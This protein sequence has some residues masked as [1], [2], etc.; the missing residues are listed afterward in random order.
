MPARARTLQA[1]L[2]LLA[3]V[4]SNGALAQYSQPY[5]YPPPPPP[6]GY[7]PAP[8]QPAP[9][10]YGPPREPAEPARGRIELSGF[11]GYQFS[12]N[13]G[14]CCGTIRID[15]SIDF[16]AALSYEVR[17]GYS[18]ELLWVMVPTKLRFDSNGLV[19]PGSAEKSDVTLNYIQIG[20]VYG[21]KRGRLEPFFSLTLGVIIV[22][23]ATARLT[24]G[25]TLTPSTQVKFAFTGGGGL[26]IWIN[27]RFA[28]RLEIRALVPV[29]FTGTTFFVG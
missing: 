21:L 16:G 25:T 24:D 2:V 28:V 27:E 3:G 6:P 10:Y 9:G 12:T 19:F 1:V 22:S 7:Y 5:P 15:D 18:V 4:A 20:G 13:V 23:P 17:R 26:K 29:Y 11:V 8:A 14:T